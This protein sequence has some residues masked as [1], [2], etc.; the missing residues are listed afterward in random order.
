MHITRDLSAREVLSR[1]LTASISDVISLCNRSVHGETIRETDADTVISVGT[2]LLQSLDYVLR[3]YG[4]GH[5]V[6]EIEITESE[7]DDYRSARYKVVTVTPTI[8]IAHQVTY[9]LTHDELE[10]F[11][12]GYS[13]FAQFVVGIEKIAEQDATVIRK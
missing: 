13:E 4:V 7:I 3:D 1:D 6:G 9:I 2:D 5:P 8:P 12:D 10:D 11:F